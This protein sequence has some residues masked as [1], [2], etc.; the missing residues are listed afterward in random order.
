MKGGLNFH[1]LESS[2][3]FGWVP[4]HT[5]CRDPIAKHISNPDVCCAIYFNNCGPVDLCWVVGAVLGQLREGGAG[6]RPAT[7]RSAWVSREGGAGVW[8][9]TRRRT[10]VSR[11][12][13]AG[14]WPGIK[15]A[16]KLLIT[17]S[18]FETCFRWDPRHQR[19]WDP[20]RR[21]QVCALS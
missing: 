15:W 14:V 19:C 5:K 8:P 3:V 20:T 10:W 7:R 11:E 13:G 12:G 1:A 6:V 16:F 17:E 4:W 21:R 2:R 9:G 18:E